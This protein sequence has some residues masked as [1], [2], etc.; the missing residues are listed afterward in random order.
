MNLAE[1]LRSIAKLQPSYSSRNTPA[2]QERGQ[3]IRRVVPDLLREMGIDFRIALGEFGETFEVDSSDGIGRKTEAPW[4]RICSNE[5]SPSARDGFYVVI[6]FAANGSAIYITVGCGSTIWSD[7]ELRPIAPYELRARTDWARSVIEEKFGNTA[8]FADEIYLGARANL[9]AVFERATVI[10]KRVPTESASDT[11][12]RQ[13]LLE[14]TIRLRTVYW[15]QRQ[16]RHLPAAEVSELDVA[17]VIRPKRT[18][19]TGQGYALSG[20]ERRAIEL[21]AMALAKE[22]LVQNGFSVV[23]RSAQESFDFEA[24]RDGKSTKV[25]VKGTTSDAADAVLMT[26]NEVE[27]HTNYRGST[28]LIIVHGIRVERVSREI[29][30]FE[31]KVVAELPWD[32][33]HWDL[34]PMAFR[35]TKRPCLP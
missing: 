25:E 20:P 13:L 12:I 18:V 6:H 8:P 24:T 26:K 32:I 3:L 5:M 35:L 15:A 21:R 30:G 16:G 27:L 14:A 23:D 17:S 7:G 4:I 29:M 33:G 34:Q 1:A 28:G 9:P 22:W 2:M 11:D 19:A 10:A 31:G